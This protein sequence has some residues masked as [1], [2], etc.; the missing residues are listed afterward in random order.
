VTTARFVLA[1]ASATRRQM[2]EQAGLRIEVD[3]ARVDEDEVKRALKAEQVP[4]ERA[5][6]ALAELKTLRISARHADALVIGADQMLESDGVWFDKP[7]D[8]AGAAAQLRALRGRTHLLVSSAV[9]ALGGAR[10]WHATEKARLTMRNFS[11]AFLDTYLDEVGDAALHAVG[12]YQLEGRGVQ[13]FSRVEGDF[14]TILGLPLLPLL[15]FLRARGA[16][17]A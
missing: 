2:L 8:R 5:A 14:F 17:Q 4:V 12:G 9:V 6:E 15:D 10:L 3:P 16:L 1:S 7:A 11:D 13:L